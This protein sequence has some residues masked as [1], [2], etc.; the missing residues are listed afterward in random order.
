MEIH[1]GIPAQFLVC[2]AGTLRELS[3]HV[4][5]SA[6]AGHN[7]LRLQK[8]RE[9]LDL[10][11]EPSSECVL[12]SFGGTGHTPI[13]GSPELNLLKLESPE[14]ERLIMSQQDEGVLHQCPSGVQITAQSLMSQLEL[15]SNRNAK[16]LSPIISQDDFRFITET[17]R[18]LESILPKSRDDIDDNESHSFVFGMEHFLEPMQ[19]VPGNLE[20]ERHLLVQTEAESSLLDM[21]QHQS[22]LTVK[23]NNERSLKTSVSPNSMF[24]SGNDSHEGVYE[25]IGNTETILESNAHILYDMAQPSMVPN[26]YTQSKVDREKGSR[27]A[28]LPLPPID[29]EVQ[30]IVKR[31]RKKLKNRVAASKC[32]K[33]KLE[34]EAQL[35]VRVQQ[36]KEKNIELNALANALRQQSG[37]LR[38]RILDHVN[39]GC[40]GTLM[41]Y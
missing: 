9:S 20:A 3:H 15:N 29:L 23:Q 41:H 31:E 14:L 26:P 19:Q 35:E 18:A 37:E 11:L 40:P 7:A 25:R 16:A 4:V 22:R 32:R 1:G 28:M 30:E 10:K 6:F 17:N 27:L 2:D 34:R 24:Q 5:H 38:Q 33:K 12:Q 36:L 21:R 39:N 13:L 8:S